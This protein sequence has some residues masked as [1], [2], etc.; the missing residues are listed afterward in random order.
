M[1]VMTD[2]CHWVAAEP[3]LGKAPEKERQTLWL[4]MEG[5]EP[6]LLLS[7]HTDK[8]Q[9]RKGTCSQNCEVG[10]GWGSQESVALKLCRNE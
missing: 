9:N 10:E 3:R 8:C 7:S 1:G 2:M 5:A 6:F 4:H